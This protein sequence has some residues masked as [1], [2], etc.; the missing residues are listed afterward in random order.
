MSSFSDIINGNTPVLVD[1]YTNWCA[2]CKMMP[3]ILREVKDKLGDKIRIV[4]IDTEK[5]PAISQRY[6][7]RSIPTMILFK[8]GIN[9]WQTSGVMP[10]T[11]LISTIENYL[12]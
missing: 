7:I 11:Q 8:N 9:K 5:N 1:F 12:N 6:Q 4:K 10:A 2:P 3:P